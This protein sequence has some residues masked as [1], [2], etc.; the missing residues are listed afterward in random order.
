MPAIYTKRGQVSAYG[1]ACGYEDVYTRDTENGPVNFALS[2][3]GCTYDVNVIPLGALREFVEIQG[4]GKV[5]M[6]WA[7]FDTLAEARK[8]HK[9]LALSPSVGF[10]YAECLTKHY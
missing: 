7:Q 5:L 9:R 3:N 10:A 4:K 6:G 8:F 2:Y 1:L